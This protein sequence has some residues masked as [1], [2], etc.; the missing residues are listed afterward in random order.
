MSERKRKRASYESSG[1]L[2]SKTTTEQQVAAD[3]V[4]VSVLPDEDEWAPIVGMVV[5]AH[6]SNHNTL[7]YC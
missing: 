2:G 6:E 1:A 7:P 4:K 3:V 5:R